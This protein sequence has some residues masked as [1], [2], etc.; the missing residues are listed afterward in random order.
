MK[1]FLATV[2]EAEMEGSEG[3]VANVKA[4]AL[5]MEKIIDNKK[6]NG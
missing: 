1:D 2:H 5:T 4:K 6:Q 3:K